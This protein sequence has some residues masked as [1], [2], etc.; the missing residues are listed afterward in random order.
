MK[1]APATALIAGFFLCSPVYAAT[2]VHPTAAT[3]SVENNVTVWRGAKTPAAHTVSP[4][5]D[6]CHATNISV[7]LTGF[8]PRTLRTHG[9]WSGRKSPRLSYA[10]STHGFYA[11]RIRAGM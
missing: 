6:S 8:A 2:L 3:K 4:I 7:T 10:V 5:A 11:D 9:F 1:P